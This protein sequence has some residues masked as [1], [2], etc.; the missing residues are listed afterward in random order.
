MSRRTVLLIDDEP[1]IREVATLSLELDPQIECRAVESG[2]S[3]LALLA[4]G[5]WRP[6]LILLDVMMPGMDGPATLAALRGMAGF[7]ATP[8]VFMTARARGFEQEH[9]LQLGA[10]GVIPKPFDPMS[11]AVQLRSLSRSWASV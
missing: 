2:A 6:D 7:A 9:L 5:P 11:L 1:D 8:V 3:A 10:I 4:D